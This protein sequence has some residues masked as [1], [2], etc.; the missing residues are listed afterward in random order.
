M[1]TPQDLSYICMN[2]NKLFQQTRLRL[3]VW[4]ALVMAVILSLCGYGVYRVVSYNHRLALKQELQSVA[5]TLHDSIELKLQKP[6]SLEPV[7]K[8]LLPNICIVGESCIPVQSSSHRHIL[9]AINQSNYYV[10]F[11]AISEKLIA[12][13]GVYPQGLSS[14]FN[15]ATWQSFTDPQGIVYQQISFVLHT[16]DNRDWGYIQVGRSLEDLSRYLQTIKITLALGLPLALAVVG[17]ASWWLAGLAIQPIY[18]SYQQVQ[19]FTADVAHELRTP[20][21]A[22]QATVESTLFMSEVNETEAREVL[23]TIQRQNQR[24]TNLVT[25]LL[26]LTRLDYQSIPIQEDM[27]CLNDIINDLIEEFAALAIASNVRLTT[28]V[29][30]TAPLNIMGNEDQLYR[31]FSNLIVNAIKYTPAGGKVTIDLNHNEYY[32][33]IQIEDTGVGIPQAEIARIFD[34]F[35]RVNSDRSRSTG[36]SG[37]GLAIAQAIVHAHHGS[38]DAHST[39]EI[40]SK[41]TVK[42][43]FN[44]RPQKNFVRLVKALPNKK[45]PKT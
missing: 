43:P 27:C 45:L 14:E 7:I 24:L 9:S 3:A 38:I 21:A 31:L 37:L 32:A 42:L 28:G 20:L 2:H 41:F 11:F 19:Q 17:L 33:V 22:N 5:G 36:G 39:L 16:Q 8:Q 23:K 1:P 25:D 13:A 12:V 35:Y 34:R 6:G 29:K 10:R 18:F 40:G 26:L 15:S 44:H 30:V 4:Y